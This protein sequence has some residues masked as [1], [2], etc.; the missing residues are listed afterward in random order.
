MALSAGRCG[1]ECVEYSR[2][3]SLLKQQTRKTKIPAG[4]PSGIVTGN[5]TGELGG[6]END[7]AII[8]GPKQT[9]V[10]S[11]MSTNLVSNSNAQAVI[12]NISSIVYNYLNV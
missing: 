12:R 4:I 7:T 3:L 9:Y 6:T 2:M 8:Y 10:L 11:I 5:K 1:S